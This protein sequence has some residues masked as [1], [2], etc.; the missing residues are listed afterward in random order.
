MIVFNT[1]RGR[2]ADKANVQLSEEMEALISGKEG[3]VGDGAQ[4]IC[5]VRG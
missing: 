5:A 3:K 2:H 1:E 4:V